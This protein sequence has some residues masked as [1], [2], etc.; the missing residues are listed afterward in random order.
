MHEYVFGICSKFYRLIIQKARDKL[1]SQPDNTIVEIDVFKIYPK[2]IIKTFFDLI[3]GIQNRKKLSIC[4]IFQIIDLLY[5]GYTDAI[6]FPWH[7]RRGFLL[8]KL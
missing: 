5:Y 4:E 8:R 1:K 3:Y 2:A 7:F 6:E